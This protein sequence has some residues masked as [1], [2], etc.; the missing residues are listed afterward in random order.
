MHGTDCSY[1]SKY[2][3]YLLPKCPSA[4]T[5][6]AYS[7]HGDVLTLS[8]HVLYITR[9]DSTRYANGNL[10]LGEARTGKRK[11]VNCSVIS[12]PRRSIVNAESTSCLKQA[13]LY[14][15]FIHKA[16]GTCYKD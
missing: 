11:H 7:N 15:L 16:L 12:G 1:S 8:S 5:N 13:E 6:T 3:F 14:N 4:R 9:I 2:K 10:D